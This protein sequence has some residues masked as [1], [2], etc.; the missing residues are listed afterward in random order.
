M[1]F[2]SGQ[3]VRGSFPFIYKL[4]YLFVGYLLYASTASPTIINVISETY[5]RL[6]VG[7][8]SHTKR[9]NYP[10]L[11]V[12]SRSMTNM[13]DG[14]LWMCFLK[15][16]T[17]ISIHRYSTYVNA[18]SSNSKYASDTSCFHFHLSSVDEIRVL[19]RF[20]ITRW[21]Y[22]RVLCDCARCSTEL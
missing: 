19:S 5:N 21:I 15:K 9:A 8:A 18:I 4:S 6:I 10:V 22:Q 12:F 3:K 1:F 11:W 2:F 7:M 13:S 17:R 20:E 14:R 16:P